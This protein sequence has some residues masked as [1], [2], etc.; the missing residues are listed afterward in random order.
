MCLRILMECACP[1]ILSPHRGSLP[2]VYADV[3]AVRR[4]CLVTSLQAAAI[5]L[6]TMDTS[7]YKIVNAFLREVDRSQLKPFFP[8]MKLD[9]TGQKKNELT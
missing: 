1:C 9:M 3:R 2:S 7:F 6:Y 4:V 5:Y 8:Y